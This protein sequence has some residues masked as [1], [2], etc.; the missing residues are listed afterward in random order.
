MAKPYR[1]ERPSSSSSSSARANLASCLVATVF[2]IFLLIVILVVYFT[3]FKPQDPKI[4]ISAV[5]LPSFSVSNGS[6]SFTFSQNASVRNPNRALFS[7]YDSSLQLIYSG[8]QVGFMFIP[9]GHID[10]GT[11]KH[12]AATFSVQSFPLFT[13]SSSSADGFNEV[14]VGSTM[15]IESK[16]MMAGRVKVLYL[17][18]HRVMAKAGCR[19]AIGVSDG[20][21]LGLHC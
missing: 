9:A 17:F 14:R 16:M 19:V 18:S 4:S 3:V 8:N 5:R 6:V 13:P 15:E 10:A 12:M 11:T 2:L 1:R 7:H 20:S 21:V